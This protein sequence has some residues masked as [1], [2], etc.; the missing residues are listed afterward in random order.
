MS[1]IANSKVVDGKLK[2]NQKPQFKFDL[3]KVKERE[4]FNR[5]FEESKKKRVRKLKRHIF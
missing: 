4:Y 3:A 2:I 5:F 1:Q